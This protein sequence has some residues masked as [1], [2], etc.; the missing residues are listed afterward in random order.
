[1][2]RGSSNRDAR[3]VPD[4]RTDDAPRVAASTRRP[5]T[6]AHEQRPPVHLPRG[7]ERAV[8]RTGR[9]T[10]ELRGPEVDVLG[11]VGT[12]RNVAVRD[13]QLTIYGGD[14]ATITHDLA[15]LEFQGL[16][17]RRQV[18][19]LDAPA[20]DVVALT[21][22]GQRLIE[23]SRPQ[24]ADG[25]SVPRVYRGFVKPRNLPHDVA[26]YPMV[27][28][29]REA[30]GSRGTQVTRIVLEAELRHT[31]LKAWHAASRDHDPDEAKRTVAE[32]CQ[33]PLV[34]DRFQFPDVR[35]ELEHADGTRAHVDLELVTRHY[36]R[37][38]LSL[39][40]E[41]G[42]RLYAPYDDGVIGPILAL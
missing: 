39:K 14:R 12:F 1:M 25:A 10:Y 4:P 24:P 29:E 11:V 15:D 9:A 38:H 13:L 18:A 42:F 33:L 22:A 40:A 20:L 28:R 23:A 35:L 34:N 17:E 5:Q 26:L 3:D 6:A 21:P 19:M 41:A 36:H 7:A 30:L 27:E 31:V 16:L 32:A 8:V 2:S 37:G